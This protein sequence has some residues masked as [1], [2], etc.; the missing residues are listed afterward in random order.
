M[1]QF[2][3]RDFCKD[4]FERDFFERDFFKK[5]LF[6][7]D[8]RSGKL[9]KIWPI[10]GRSLGFRIIDSVYPYICSDVISTAKAKVSTCQ[11]YVIRCL[12]DIEIASAAGY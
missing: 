5:D 3:S 7:S 11:R 2:F 1:K 4:F 12:F 10:E 9:H 8:L 6:K